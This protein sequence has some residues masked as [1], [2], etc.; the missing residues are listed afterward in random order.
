MQRKCDL[1]YQNSYRTLK[2]YLSTPVLSSFIACYCFFFVYFF[3]C[4]FV[5]CTKCKLSKI[6]ALFCLFPIEEIR[7]C[8][9]SVHL[10]FVLTCSLQIHIGRFR[11]FQIYSLFLFKYIRKIICSIFS[12]FEFGCKFILY[13]NRKPKIIQE[14]QSETTKTIYVLLSCCQTWVL[15]DNVHL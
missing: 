2:R 6:K 8:L 4:L 13:L 10:Y 5:F 9:S 3:V 15:L 7:I 1:R 12:L 14:Q 11:L